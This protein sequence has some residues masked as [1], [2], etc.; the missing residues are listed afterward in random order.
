MQK[1]QW[2]DASINVY[3]I[4]LA[5]GRNDLDRVFLFLFNVDKVFHK[6]WL[7]TESVSLGICVG[8]EIK[9]YR[10]S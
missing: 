10:A 8:V 9:M 3:S 1:T 5:E 6:S 4:N 2:R 7:V